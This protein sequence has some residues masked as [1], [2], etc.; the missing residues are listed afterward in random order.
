MRRSQSPVGVAERH[1]VLLGDTLEGVIL[2]VVMVKRGHL[3]LVEFI[4]VM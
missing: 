1:D 4:K 2:V 3:V